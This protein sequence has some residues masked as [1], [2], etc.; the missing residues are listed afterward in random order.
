MME[1]EEERVFKIKTHDTM[2]IEHVSR[3]F[4]LFF[5]VTFTEI[6]NIVTRSAD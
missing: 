6:S 2:L 5:A 1:A 3:F 4:P